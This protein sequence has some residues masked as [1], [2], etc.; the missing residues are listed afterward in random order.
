MAKK[1]KKESKDKRVIMIMNRIKRDID[2]VPGV[3]RVV[4][5]F[6]KTF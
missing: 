5:S 3:R 6:V 1:Y 4:E 2:P